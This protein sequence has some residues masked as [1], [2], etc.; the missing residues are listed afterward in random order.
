VN[1]KLITYNSEDCAALELV[2]RAVMQACKKGIGFADSPAAVPLEVVVADKL[3]SYRLARFQNDDVDEVQF[4]Y[5]W[6]RG[7]QSGRP[8]GLPAGP[9]LHQNRRGVEAREAEEEK[10]GKAGSTH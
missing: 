7:H 9:H 2:V 5:R 1:E 8:L 6:L 4:L 3:A 10:P